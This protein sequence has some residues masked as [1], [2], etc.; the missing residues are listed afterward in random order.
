M[1]VIITG[2]TLE[3]FEKEHTCTEV[4]S[5]DQGKLYIYFGWSNEIKSDVIQQDT[6]NRKQHRGLFAAR[7][8]RK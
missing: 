6:I 8:I 7:N 4:K 5:P 1:L 2:E 3:N